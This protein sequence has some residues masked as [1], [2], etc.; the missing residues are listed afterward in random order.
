MEN[1][2]LLWELWKLREQSTS[3]LI[4]KPPPF[5]SYEWEKR[6]SVTNNSTHPRKPGYQKQEL[7][8]WGSSPPFFSCLESKHSN[9]FMGTHRLLCYVVNLFL[10]FSKR[11]WIQITSGWRQ[12]LFNS[13]QRV[14]ESPSILGESL[15]RGWMWGRVKSGLTSHSHFFSTCSP[16]WGAK[17][18]EI[19]G[20]TVLLTSK[21][22]N[23]LYVLEL[24]PG[25]K[26]STLS[27]AFSCQSLSWVV[28]SCQGVLAGVTGWPRFFLPK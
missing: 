10:L 4:A 15:R 7:R 28:G 18:H 26:R 27:S 2:V 19:N 11:L 9:L 6:K 12:L 23:G 25:K 14:S 24:T 22:V 20:Y 17:D 5:L 3:H 1:K 8:S 13:T 21:R 16:K